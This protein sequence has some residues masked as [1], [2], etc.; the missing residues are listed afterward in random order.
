MNR[1]PFS[2]PAIPVIRAHTTGGAAASILGDG[3]PLEVAAVFERSFYC[4][5]AGDRWLCFLRDDL[6]PGPLHALA[7][8]WPAR[9]R[10]HVSPGQTLVFRGGG[11]WRGPTLGIE[12]GARR[13][14]RPP[15]FPPPDAA[16]LRRALP[17][18]RE[19][20]RAL[21]PPDTLAGLLAGNARPGGG[22]RRLAATEALRG[23]AA[24]TRW[25]SGPGGRSPREAVLG[26]LGL[27][28]GL[29]P[30]GDDVL[31]GTLLALHA[32]GRERERRELAAA[33][34][35]QGPAGTNRI[36]LAHLRAAAAGQG[37]A[38]FHDALIELNRGG[39]ALDGCLRR[40]GGI[41]HSSGWDA[42]A[43]MAA[44]LE[45]RAEARQPG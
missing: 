17:R 14:W 11:A 23:L 29:T 32:L 40:I 9:P 13:E 33:A 45:S 36:S 37:A 35:E 22:W 8:N 34:L 2:D 31:A 28:A 38:P 44:T 25:L 15:P 42:L 41:G 30:T 18:L 1:A 10:E 7:S 3:R 4:R 21:A 26:L 5:D 16:A 19:A 27:G 6:E 12:C 39:E 43:G 24:L 20:M